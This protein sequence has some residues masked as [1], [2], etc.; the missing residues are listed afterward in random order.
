MLCVG[1]RTAHGWNAPVKI[2][3]LGPTVCKLK[4]PIG[5]I[6]N[7]VQHPLYCPSRL[8]EDIDRRGKDTGTRSAMLLL[9]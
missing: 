3:K 8:V 6:E 2:S 1:N 4:L 9:F 5:P 7:A